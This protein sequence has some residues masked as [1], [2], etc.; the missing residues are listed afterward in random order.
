MKPE[1]VKVGMRVRSTRTGRECTVKEADGKG[2]IRGIWSG[3]GHANNDG[4]N[5]CNGVELAAGQPT[6][7]LVEEGFGVNDGSL[8]IVSASS[9]EKAVENWDN[10]TYVHEIGK[11]W[12]V[13][14]KTELVLTEE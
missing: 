9:P 10:A 14:T 2:R 5:Y 11:S 7:Y 4:W 1:D 13:V 6:K 12:E 3:G 8:R